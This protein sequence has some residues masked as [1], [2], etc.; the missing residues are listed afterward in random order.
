MVVSRI[1][2]LLGA[3]QEVSDRAARAARAAAAPRALTLPR[4]LLSL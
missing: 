3:S 4:P 1:N 2:A